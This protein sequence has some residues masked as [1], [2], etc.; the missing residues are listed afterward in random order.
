[1]FF[2][3]L[4][5]TSH[6]QT[7]KLSL[8]LLLLLL[9]F[10]KQF[11]TGLESSPWVCFAF[12]FFNRTV[13]IFFRWSNRGCKRLPTLTLHTFF[14]LTVVGSGLDEVL[15]HS[16]SPLMLALS[17]SPPIVLSHLLS[18]ALE[19]CDQAGGSSE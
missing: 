15:P 3:S 7:K 12:S 6:T 8:R 17:F 1:M 10:I 4:L 14:G 9:F 18:L 5:L 13:C 16:L 2:K 11:C 19:L